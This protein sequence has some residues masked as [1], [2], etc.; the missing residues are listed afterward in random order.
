MSAVSKTRTVLLVL[1]VVFLNAAGNLA[2]AWGMKHTGAVVLR[3][4]ITY[5]EPMLQPAVAVGIA[6]LILWLLTRMTLL[7]WADLSYVLPLTSLGYVLAA[8]FGYLFLHERATVG[9]WVGVAL[10]FAGS[11]LVGS[12]EGRTAHSRAEE[13]PA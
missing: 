11:L 6:L 4:P 10:I 8:L 2:L 1:A 5:I 7:S 13:S 12:T 9:H 3:R